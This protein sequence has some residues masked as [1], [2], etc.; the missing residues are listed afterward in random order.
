MHLEALRRKK[1]SRFN[2]KH[3][4]EIIDEAMHA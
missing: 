4:V 1:R 2:I 3:I